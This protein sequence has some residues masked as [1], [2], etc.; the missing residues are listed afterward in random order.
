[1]A[2]TPDANTEVTASG[3]NASFLW[4]ILSHFLCIKLSDKVDFSGGA[5][6]NLS[7]VQETGA[8]SPWREGT[9]VSVCLFF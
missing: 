6:M 5:M 7:S 9:P 2:G 4:I 1:M 8:H 3:S